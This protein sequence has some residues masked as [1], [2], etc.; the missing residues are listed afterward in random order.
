MYIIFRRQ[1]CEWKKIMNCLPFDLQGTQ[2]IVKALSQFDQAQLGLHNGIMNIVLS[3]KKHL[4]FQVGCIFPI[5]KTCVVFRLLL[6]QNTSITIYKPLLYR[7]IPL[8]NILTTNWKG[9]CCNYKQIL[10]TMFSRV[11]IF[12]HELWPFQHKIFTMKHC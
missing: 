7:I 1:T 6:T 9:K 8:T 12:L 4:F 3:F 2:T 11:F 5:R 10:H